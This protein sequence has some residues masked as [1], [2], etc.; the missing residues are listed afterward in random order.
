[1]CILL[2]SYSPPPSCLFL[3]FPYFELLSHCGVT[4]CLRPS[5]PFHFFTGVRSEADVG[6]KVKRKVT[7]RCRI[8]STADS[9]FY[10][11]VCVCPSPLR[12]F[13]YHLISF[14]HS[15]YV[16]STFSLCSFFLSLL[17]VLTS[18]FD[19]PSFCC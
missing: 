18:C 12:T 7:R 4:I 1:M 6:K 17:F 15:R 14:Y 3:F 19:V 10:V 2:W 9:V 5:F 16:V 8:G 11:D 13:S